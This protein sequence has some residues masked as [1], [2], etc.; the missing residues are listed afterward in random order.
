MS[1]SQDAR[2]YISYWIQKNRFD[3]FGYFYLTIKIHKTLLSTRP[4]C[5]DCASLV[6]PLGKWLD[7]ALQPVIVDTFLLQRFVLTEARA[8]QDCPPPQPKHHNIQ[9]HLHVHKHQHRRQHRANL[10][11]PS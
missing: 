1:L 7:H 4:V 5:S 11:V 8:G 2:N 10:N 9:R 6:H 3:P